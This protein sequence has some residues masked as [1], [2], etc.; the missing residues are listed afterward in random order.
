MLWNLILKSVQFFDKVANLLIEYANFVVEG[1]NFIGNK[2]FDTV[3]TDEFFSVGSPAH[4]NIFLEGC[5]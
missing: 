1:S 2:A 3:N 4:G 5:E